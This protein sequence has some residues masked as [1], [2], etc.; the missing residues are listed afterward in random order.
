MPNKDGLDSAIEFTKLLI[1]LDSA[2]IAFA[3]GTSFLAT[4][5]EPWQRISL[6]GALFFLLVSLT[7]GALVLMRAATMLS[8]QNYNLSD[9]HLK[10]PGVL[11][12]LCFACGAA[13][14]SLLAVFVIFQSAPDPAA[15]P[16]IFC[17]M[18]YMK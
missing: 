10:V 14:I 18:C 11:N 15:K 5:P 16:P 13:A 7:A 17:F 6:V 2:L 3:S 9:P 1:S 4:L 8:H 12:V